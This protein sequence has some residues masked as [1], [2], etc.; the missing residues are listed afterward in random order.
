MRSSPAV[1]R[2]GSIYLGTNSGSPS[3]VF[4]A[5]N[6][7]GTLK[8]TF[9]PADLPPDVPSSHFDI[10]SSPTIGSDGTIYFGQEFGRV[11]ALDPS[12]GAILWMVETQSGIT[13]SSPALT[14]LGTLLITDLSG[15]LYAMETDSRGLDAQAPWPKF[16]H[17]NRNSG[18]MIP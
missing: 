4:V 18:S 5:L 7:N 15:R 2:D 6:P 1:A 11:Y 9:E 14:G 17:D 8:W 10:Y 3:S 12:S 13:W 16:R